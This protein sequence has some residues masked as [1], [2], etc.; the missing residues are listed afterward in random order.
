MSRSEPP[1]PCGRELHGTP[2]AFLEPP[3]VRSA[4]QVRRCSA[5]RSAERV[6][7]VKTLKPGVVIADKYRLLAPL[8]GGGMGALWRALHV[9]LNVEVALKFPQVAALASCDGEWRLRFEREA[10]AAAKLQNR[11]VVPIRDYGID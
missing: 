4:K 10:R 5:R 3:K 9:L 6:H 2:P 1:T 11:F 7:V 8:G